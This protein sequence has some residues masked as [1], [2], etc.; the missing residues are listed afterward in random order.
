MSSPLADNNEV[1]GLNLISPL[2]GNAIGGT[3]INRFNIN[4]INND[5]DLALAAPG[6]NSGA[7]AGIVLMN[8][9]GIGT[10]DD[11]RFNSTQAGS[12]GGIVVQNTG[13]GPFTLNLS[14][15][16]FSQGGLFGVQVVA[17]NSD[18]NANLTNV[19]ANQT[20][21]G[22]RLMSSNGGR[23]T[24]TVNQ[25]NFN[26]ST[27][28]GVSAIASGA[29][30]RI[31]LTAS[32]VVA[33]DNMADGFSL[34]ALMGG[35]Y[36]AVVQNSSLNNNDRNA[37]RSV[38]TDNS[39]GMLTVTN[40]TGTGS[41]EHGIFLNALSGSVLNT[42]TLTGVNVSNSGQGAGVANDGVNIDVS[43]MGSAATVNL[44][45][46]TAVNTLG[47]MTQENGL[48]L[49]VADGG[50]LTSVVS[51]INFSANQVSGISTRVRN[52]L[53]TANLTVS[54]TTAD[55]STMAP[56]ADGF[57]FDNDNGILTA[58]VTTSSFNNSGRNAIRGL[59]GLPSGV[60]LFPDDNERHIRFHDSQRQWRRRRFT[61]YHWRGW[62]KRLQLHLSAN[63]T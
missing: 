23:I 62:S 2:N 1:S 47:N 8:V 21:D 28:A 17:N 7:G 42:T 5:I 40:T 43:G 56:N 4:N 45:N 18:V 32:N 29:N 48:R 26:N 49:L 20:G 27:G 50:M 37:I 22:L 24:A 25:S 52:A 54:G 14:N 57:V 6:N 13:V 31:N 58:T 15:V 60:A 9:T 41:G 10:I 51:G 59:G 34:R 12:A 30:S 46:V 55:G 38:L 16:P 11:V 35:D 33:E 44:T 53:S 19:T 36:Q 3:G 39:T 61:R 63:L